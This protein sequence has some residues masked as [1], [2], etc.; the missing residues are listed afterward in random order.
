M[1]PIYD[2]VIIALTTTNQ[3]S[4]YNHFSNILPTRKIGI[5]YSFLKQITIMYGIDRSFI[6]KLFL[7]PIKLSVYSAGPPIRPPGHR[8]SPAI[9]PLFLSHQLSHR[10][11]FAHRTNAPGGPMSGPALYQQRLKIVFTP[12]RSFT[13]PTNAP[14][15]W[16]GSVMWCI[17]YFKIIRAIWNICT[18]I[19]TK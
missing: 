16:S 12:N 5:L 8:T 11:P 19:K 4:F 14:P 6:L 18:Y 2:L 9:G 7:M 10:I 17:K 15:L 3:F 1:N 13:T